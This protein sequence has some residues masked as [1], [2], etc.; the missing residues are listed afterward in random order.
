[1]FSRWCDT[2][3]GY[4]AP[5]GGGFRGIGQLFEGQME[6]SREQMRFPAIWVYFL[7][8]ALLKIYTMSASKIWNRANTKTIVNMANINVLKLCTAKRVADIAP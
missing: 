8:K 4:F 7:P 2:S 1:M 3:L 5:L 6:I